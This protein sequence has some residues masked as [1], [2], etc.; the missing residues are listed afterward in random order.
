MTERR[1]YT[2]SQVAK[3]MSCATGTVK[4]WIKQGKLKAYKLGGPTGRD[5]RVPW[6]EVERIKNEWTY[7]PET[8]KAL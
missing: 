3:I 4:N 6:A 5:Y 8:D 1:D 2:P 7:S